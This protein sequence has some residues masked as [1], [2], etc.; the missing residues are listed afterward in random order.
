MA[1]SG[2][3]GAHWVTA[4]L[5]VSLAAGV[6]QAIDT[7]SFRLVWTFDHNGIFHLI[8]LLGLAVLGRGLG[9][10]LRERSP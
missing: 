8:Q 5:A 9:R 6:V 7:V 10:A 3:A 4:G 2:R 1:R